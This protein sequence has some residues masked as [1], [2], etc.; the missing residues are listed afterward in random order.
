L[1]HPSDLTEAE[2]SLVEHHFLEGDM[3]DV[4]QEFS[5][6]ANSVWSFRPVG[7]VQG[8]ESHAQCIEHAVSKKTAKAGPSYSRID[9][10]SVKTKYDSG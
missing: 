4:A 8:V 3:P 5:V 10:Q 1:S 2:W 6:V 9:A 7:Q